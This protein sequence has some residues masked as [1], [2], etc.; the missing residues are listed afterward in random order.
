ICS[1]CTSGCRRCCQRRR[2]GQEP[3]CVNYYCSSHR[4][5]SGGWCFSRQ[6]TEDSSE[7]FWQGASNP[8]GRERNDARCNQ[9]TNCCEEAT[10]ADAKS[11][12]LNQTIGTATGDE[13]K[14]S[15]RPDVQTVR[16]DGKVDVQEVLSPGQDANASAAKY[17]NALGNKAGTIKCVP[18]DK[19]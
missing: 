3:K 19:C 16:T 17:N 9:R 11:V 1:Q 14:S 12:H 15:L 8:K 13:V 4:S 7:D 18:Q 6:S 10:R 5:H 2:S